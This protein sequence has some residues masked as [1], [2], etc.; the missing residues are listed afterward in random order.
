MKSRGVCLIFSCALVSGVVGVAACV[1]DDPTT[2]AAQNDASTSDAT[3]SDASQPGNDG[4][5]PVDAG[6][7]SGVLNPWDPVALA[8]GIDHACALR[9]DHKVYCWGDNAFGQ[10]GVNDGGAVSPKPQLVTFAA[11]VNPVQIFAGEFET[12]AIDDAGGVWCWGSGQNGGL[13]DNNGTA[14]SFPVPQ[15]VVTSTGNLAAAPLPGCSGR[16]DQGGC[17]VGSDKSLDCWGTSPDNS[18]GPTNN[19]FA[20]VANASQDDMPALSVS[21]SGSHSSAIVTH[22]GKT[23]VATWGLNS[24]GQLGVPDAGSP[25]V[26]AAYPVLPTGN[27]A[28]L[29]ATGQNDTCAVDSIGAI[30]CWGKNDFDQIGSSASGAMVTAPVGDVDFQSD[31][32]T[33]LALSD[34]TTCVIIATGDVFCFGD[35]GLGQLGALSIGSKTAAKQQI[36]T[37]S[38]DAVA[39]TAGSS[40]FCAIREGLVAGGRSVWCW[41]SNATAELGVSDA[42]TTCSGNACSP[43][44]LKI[45][46]PTE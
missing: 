33:A 11:G 21:C 3:S 2:T 10:L 28:A 26:N 38:H 16:N 36:M 20:T 19:P 31:R 43:T 15:R 29:T 41:G 35:N 40:F 5:P 17:V 32:V 22:G 30:S 23:V 34:T 45:P 7:D 14:G 8:A 27:P 18:Y 12:C 39:I 25:S 37:I 13:G 44:P 4:S 6:S 24:L 9:N 46:L 42:G 1:G